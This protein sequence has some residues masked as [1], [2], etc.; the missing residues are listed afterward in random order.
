VIAERVSVE[1]LA[2]IW[3]RLCFHAGASPAQIAEFVRE[4]IGT[5]ELV[6]RECPDCG[7]EFASPM[8]T[9]RPGHYPSEEHSL[10][11]DHLEGIAR[12]RLL[13]GRL[14]DIGCADG[15]FIEKAG[16][17]GL[18]ATG[19]DFSDE[20]VAAARARGLDAHVGDLSQARGLLGNERGFDVITMFQ[21]IEHLEDP[22][23][24]FQAL[25]R[26]ASDRATLLLGCPANRRYTRRFAHPERIGRSDYWD[27]PPQH[28]LRWTEPALR[29]FLRRHGWRVVEFVEEPLSVVGAASHLAALRGKAAGWYGNP[30]RRR[31]ETAWLGARVAACRGA[32]RV[33]GLRLFVRAERDGGGTAFGSGMN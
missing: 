24:V 11:W 25:S 10:G 31:W 17:Q 5:A 30:V 15:Q 2:D 16:E 9:W 20:D 32:G 13:R 7:L 18:H 26:A 6:F 19:I 3:S 14:L 28:C 4:D 29:A 22:E 12:L 8:R 23:A 1:A 21:V 33:T 27:Y